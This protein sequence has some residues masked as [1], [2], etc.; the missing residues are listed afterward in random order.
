VLDTLT[1]LI[2]K[3][4]ELAKYRAE[5][6]ERLFDRIIAPLYAAQQAVHQDY[7]SMFEGVLKALDGGDS[8]DEALSAL[9]AARIAKEAHRHSLVAQLNTLTRSSHL[10]FAKEFLEKSR[11]YFVDFMAG[12]HLTPSRRMQL[13]LQ[14]AGERVVY[15]P[16]DSPQYRRAKR[17]ELVRSQLSVLREAWA[18][19][20][21]EYARL[22]ALAVR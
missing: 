3:L 19:V 20:S 4:T 9:A 16:S 7:L 5:R 1:K 22:S 18:E 10:A 2:E 14:Q 11:E 15:D 12:P 13:A 17:A 21:A 6:H 8:E